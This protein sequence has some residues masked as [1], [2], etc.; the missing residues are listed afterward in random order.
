MSKPIWYHTQ[1]HQIFSQII[2]SAQYWVQTDEAAI[3]DYWA[4]QVKFMLDL[5]FSLYMNVLIDNVIAHYN[6]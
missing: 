1:E 5:K 3:T 4:I 6:K 2:F